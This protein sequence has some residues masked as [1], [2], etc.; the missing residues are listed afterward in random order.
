MRPHIASVRSARFTLPSTLCATVL[1]AGFATR[2]ALASG[3]SEIALDAPALTDLEQRAA[4]AEPKDRCFLYTELLH[5]WTEL[6]GRDMTDGNEVAAATAI[7]RADEDAAKLKGALGTD[8]KRLKNAELILEHTAHRLADMVRV[9]S[10][11]QH[12]TMQTV[13]KHLNSVHDALLAQI[14]AH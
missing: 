5:G 9:A 4:T 7:A 3:P 2:P 11:D 6:A 8:S 12:D 14:F 10:L 1:L 13:L